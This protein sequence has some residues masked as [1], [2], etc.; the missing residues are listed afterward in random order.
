MNKKVFISGAA[1]R[2]GAALARSFAEDG[3]DVIVHV[4]TSVQAGENLIKELRIN[5]PKQLFNLVSI[6]LID[7]KTVGKQ[8]KDIFSVHGY[9][10][11]IIHNASRYD[12]ATL[13]KSHPSLMEEMMAIHLFAPIEIDKVY[14]QHKDNG[15]IITLLDTAIYTNQSTHAMYLLSKKSLAEYTKM[16]AL[17]WAPSIRFNGIALGPVLPPEGKGQD[18]FNQ[19]V[20]NTPLKEVVSVGNIKASID[21]ILQ[22]RNMTGQIIN[23]DAGQHLV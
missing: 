19:V 23:C 2:V 7:W 22:N 6:N 13:L 9:P 17:E 5:Y 16:A 15:N 1:Q 12:K 4:N 11:V 18:Y 10:D 14:C 21:F 20:D 3:Y 8:I